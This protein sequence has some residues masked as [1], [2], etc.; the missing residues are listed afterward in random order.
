MNEKIRRNTLRKDTERIFAT[1]LTMIMLMTVVFGTSACSKTGSVFDNLGIEN[2]GKNGNAK[3]GKN[4]A[5]SSDPGGSGNKDD[6]TDSAGNRADGQNAG[7]GNGTSSGNGNGS[8]AG[9]IG[10][11]ASGPD[12]NTA[13]HG[14]WAINETENGY[15]YEYG[16]PYNTTVWFGGLNQWAL[17]DL[18]L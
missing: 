6:G 2:D 7:N 3:D 11:K 15:Y 14:F 10:A 13:N 9:N 5:N 8:N 12:D 4:D 18:R 1:I 17:R 16:Q